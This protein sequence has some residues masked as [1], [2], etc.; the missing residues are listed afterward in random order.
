MYIFLTLSE[1]TQISC[2]SGFKKGT[3]ATF[4]QKVELQGSEIIFG[5]CT[6]QLF[7]LIKIKVK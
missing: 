5:H 4:A 3:C 7:N 6:L 2:L 1:N